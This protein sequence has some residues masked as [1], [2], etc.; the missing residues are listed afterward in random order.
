MNSAQDCQLA[1]YIDTYFFIVAIYHTCG[2]TYKYLHLTHF[3]H[4]GGGAYT[5][6]NRRVEEFELCFQANAG[7]TYDVKVLRQIREGEGR[8]VAARIEDVETGEILDGQ[9]AI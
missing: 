3:V 8:I 2:I 9:E 6:G 1:C 4:G 7:K 5:S